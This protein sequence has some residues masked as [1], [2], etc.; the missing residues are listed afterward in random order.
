MPTYRKIVNELIQRFQT[1]NPF[2]ICQAMSIT[3]IYAHLSGVRG[4]YQCGDFGDIIYIDQSISA[5]EQSFV[6]AHELG[7]A[8]LDGDA[9]A[10]FLNRH[11]YQVIGKY[12]KA[13]DR[14]ATMLLWPDDTELLEYADL[15]LE[16]LSHMMGLPQDLVVWRY[17]QIE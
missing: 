8:L 1:V 10:I 2:E 14:F 17:Q 12:E 13:A 5:E 16:Q 6:C 3:I 9:N 4:F 15:S 11:T 7:H